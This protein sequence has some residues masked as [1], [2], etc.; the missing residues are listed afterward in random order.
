LF[1]IN[2]LKNVTIWNCILTTLPSLKIVLDRLTDTKNSPWPLWL[3]HLW[4]WPPLVIIHTTHAHNSQY[5][6][7]QC[8]YYTAVF[9][10]D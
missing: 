6:T 2:V 4:E 10:G 3:R 7:A 5:R 1:T 9:F 8:N